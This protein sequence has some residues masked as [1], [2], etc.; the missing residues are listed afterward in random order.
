M[1]A[2]FGKNFFSG[3]RM[4]QM[5]ALFSLVL[6]FVLSSCCC[7]PSRCPPLPNPDLLRRPEVMSSWNPTVLD[8]NPV[9]DEFTNRI[10]EAEQDCYKGE[11][12][13]PLTPDMFRPWSPSEENFRL[14]VGDFVAIAVFGD[15][16]TI[17]DDVCVAPDGR[18]YYNLLDNG[19][20]A[21]GRTIPD[22]RTE[23]EKEISL[24]FVEP[25]VTLSPKTSL[26]DTYSIMGRVATPGVYSTVDPLTLREAIGNAGGLLK[27]DFTGRDEVTSPEE[28]L[29]DLS[30]SFI[31]RNKRKLNVDFHDLYYNPSTDQ[32]IYIYPG[33]Y[34]Y[35]AA[36]PYAE[37]YVLGA[38]TLPQRVRYQKG[39]RLM[40]VLGDAGGW[41]I[42]YPYSA[43]VSRCIVIRGCLDCPLYVEVDLSQIYFGQM[44]DIILQPGDI[45]YVCNKTLRFGR[46]LVLTALNA[47]VQAFA[48]TAAGYYGQFVWFHIGP[49]S[50]VTDD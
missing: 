50:G 17:A 33:D 47:F 20:P 38:V 26:N 27:E 40:E 7:F 34:I 22:V 23:I 32:N 41:P 35:I 5:K 24:F 36:T 8:F 1:P 3:D 18:L 30:H 31:I 14:A 28:S 25:V 29:A 37:V 42:G 13:V 44:R 46:Q 49:G 48:A 19:I 6:S 10:A 43:D 2:I 45:I 39:M 9:L 15:D 11:G 12:H 16:E 4:R 21:A